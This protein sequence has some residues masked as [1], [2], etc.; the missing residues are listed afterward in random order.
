M[1]TRGGL[2]DD[3]FFGCSW[4]ND[5]LARALIENKVVG[6]RGNDENFNDVGLSAFEVGYCAQPPDA[7]VLLN[8]KDIKWI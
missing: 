1:R 4:D 7:A 2:S 5:A 3:P 8:F 6:G